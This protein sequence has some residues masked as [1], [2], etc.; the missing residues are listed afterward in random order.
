[1]RLQARSTLFPYT[2]LFR[3]W[4]AYIPIHRE[5]WRGMGSMLEF[6]LFMK[7]DP[8][9]RVGHNPLAAL[10]YVIVYLLI[11]VE[12]LTGLFLFSQVLGNPVLHQFIGWLPLLIDP[13]YLRLIHYFLMFVFFAFSLFWVS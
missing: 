7:F 10:S 13:G 3:S 4:F 5:Q 12:M 9:P 11:L 2:T 1:M 8:S 6:Y